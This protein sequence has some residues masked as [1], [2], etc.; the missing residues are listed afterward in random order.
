MQP[1]SE[2]D[3]LPAEAGEDVA[4]PA[5]AGEDVP[6]LALDV[7][8]GP[9]D[10]LLG[11]IEGHELDITEVSL[12]AVT[13]QYMEQL[14]RGTQ[15]NV[16]ALARFV[17]VGARLLLLKSRALLPHDQSPDGPDD[18][19]DGTDPQSLLEALREYRRF[20]LAAEELATLD[21]QR[22]S[23]YRREAAPPAAPLASGLD[24]VTLDSL[25]GLFREVMER[26]PE[27]EQPEIVAAEP[28]RLADRVDRLVQSLDRERRLSFRRFVEGAHSR[29]EVI[30]DFLAVL[31]LIKARFLA[32]E[33]AE[34]FGDIDLVRLDGATAPPLAQLPDEFG[35]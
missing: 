30:V 35:G 19:Q 12:L 14:H 15:I 3:P 5:E 17:A 13:E 10:L 16:D 23:G 7:F 8:E 29:V 34:S 11:L 2:R 18:A 22:R 1:D 26:L 33:Q 6:R 4:L 20:K 31:E 32:A 25:V 27:Q 21:R 28:V 9:L 24:Q